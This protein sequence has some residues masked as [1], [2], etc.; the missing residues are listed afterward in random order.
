MIDDGADERRFGAVSRRME[1]MD[2]C[3]CGRAPYAECCGPLLE[4]Q[5]AAE[6]PEELMRSRYTAFVKGDRFHLARTWH[7]R[8][9]PEDVSADPSTRWTDLQILSS[10]DDGDTGTVDFV[11][12]FEGRHGPDELREHSRFAR[13][14]GR[15]V[16]VDGDVG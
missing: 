12:R 1:G 16:Y 9:R 3:P 8:T 6:T 10:A 13:R 15:W 11:A 14:A 7:P 4:G 2:E 5:R